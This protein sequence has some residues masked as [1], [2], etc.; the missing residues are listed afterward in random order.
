MF[1]SKCRGAGEYLGNG[2][3]LQDCPECFGSGEVPVYSVPQ[4]PI[5][6][7]S[8]SYRNAIKE[9][10]DLNPKIDR[11]TAHKLFAEAYNK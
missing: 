1:C 8:A 3:I 11:E 7:R 4:K 10:M 5:D 6:K 2:M 9:I